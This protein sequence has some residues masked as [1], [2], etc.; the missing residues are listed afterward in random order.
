MEQYDR[1][2]QDQPGITS[3]MG[4]YDSAYNTVEDDN[5]II[6]TLNE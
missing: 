3:V 5:E 2:I 4:G 6:A 1:M